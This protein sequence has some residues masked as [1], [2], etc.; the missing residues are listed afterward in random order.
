LCMIS[1]V[2]SDSQH[3]PLGM[4]MKCVHVGLLFICTKIFSIY[5]FG[6]FDLDSCFDLVESNNP[7]AL[8]INLCFHSHPIGK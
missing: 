3:Q 1:A 5:R 6:V 8:L 2:D 7:C 4:H